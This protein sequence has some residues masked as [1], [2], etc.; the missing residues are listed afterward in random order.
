LNLIWIIPAEGKR[1]E[2]PDFLFETVS[3]APGEAVN[4]FYEIFMAFLIKCV[5]PAKAGIQGFF[6][7]PRFRN[8]FFWI[9]A[10]VYSAL[11]RGT[12]MTENNISK[13]TWIKN[14]NSD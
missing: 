9:P 4:F 7:G 14:V 2:I 11:Y 5:I 13:I 3:P 12:G 10:E 6:S 1:R 8:N